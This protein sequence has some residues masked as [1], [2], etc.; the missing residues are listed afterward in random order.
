MTPHQKMLVQTSF[1]RVVPI[2]ET[3]AGLFYAK[4]FELD[5]SLRPMFTGDIE[6]QGRKLMDILRVAVNGLNHLDMLVPAVRAMGQRHAGY[7]VRDEHYETVAVALISTL[8][9][10][11]GDA[12]TDEVREAWTTVYWLLAY[13]MRA[14]AAEEELAKSA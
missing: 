14:G 4:L 13:T 2:A 7:G 1:A 5:P 10:G 12:F 3:A 8:E 11:L 6:E 9:L